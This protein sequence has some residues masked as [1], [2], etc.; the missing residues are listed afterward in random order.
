MPFHDTLNQ[1]RLAFSLCAL[2][3]TSAICGAQQSKTQPATSVPAPARPALAQPQ[4]PA[5]QYRQ[6]TQQYTPAPQNGSSQTPQPYQR[7]GQ[8]TQQNNQ[9]PFNGSQQQLQR[10]TASLYS[11][12]I[13]R[14]VKP[15]P[16]SGGGA[17]YRDRAGKTVVT[18]SKGQ[19]TQFWDQNHNVSY[20]TRGEVRAVQTSHNGTTT[21]LT[22]H[23]GGQR[24]IQTRF[25]DGSRVVNYGPHNGFVE[26]TISGRPGFV[27]RTYAI[28]G[29]TS[30]SVYRTY[31]YQNHQYYRYIPAVYYRPAFYAW[32]ITPWSSPIVYSW[33]I[34]ASGGY[35]GAYFTP[36]T[37]YPTADLWLTDYVINAGLQQSYATQQ[38]NGAI[39][40]PLSGTDNQNQGY[41]IQSPDTSS[42]SVGG[43]VSPTSVQN[44]LDPSVKALIDQQVK[45]DIAEMQAS[46]AAVADA[47]TSNA[48]APADNAVPDALK[49][50][51]TIFQV[52][53]DI[54]LSYGDDQ[55]CSV[56]SGDILWRKPDSS[57]DAT[58]N[59]D[60]IVVGRKPGSC[61]KNT[62]AKV[63]LATLQEMNNQFEQQMESGMAVL[64]AKAGKGPFP[65]S[66][67]TGRIQL[68]VG[69]APTPAQNVDALIAQNQVN[70]NQAEAEVAS[71]TSP[72]N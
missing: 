69:Q 40:Q 9:R 38:A 44:E 61:D 53:T 36:Y 42:Q 29:V 20:S 43:S 45:T 34:S 72:S 50:D 12:S 6:Q 68:A 56:T 55:T 26:R 27:A 54:Q 2:I 48:P 71:A 47:P 16:L 17:Q 8:T 18:N 3:M 22:Y 10:P 58:G 7:N 60:V 51:H 49:P 14:G 37:S 59:V 70:G 32:I 63:T 65:S 13:P 46:S 5:P 57:V 64:A 4:Q 24:T 15:Q 52:S 25:A 19:V 39:Q 35:D 1:Y 31:S 41:A 23:M 67:D 21:M 28:G 33:G 62:F 66:P 11:P 30:V